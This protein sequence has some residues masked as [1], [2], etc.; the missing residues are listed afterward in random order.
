MEDIGRLQGSRFAIIIDEAHSS[1]S[2]SS[3]TS[4]KR[5]LAGAT[6]ES[7]A[8]EDAAPGDDL[9]D[10]IAEITRARGRQPNLSMFAFTTTPK[11]KTLELFGTPDSQ[12]RYQAF[13]LYSMRQAIEG[14]R[15]RTGNKRHPPWGR[16]VSSLVPH[17]ASLTG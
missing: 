10:R 3:V 13:S 17:P 5:V 1:S 15:G 2:G 8:A 4:M 7:A 14:T 16:A 12:G 9:E 11:P 6:L